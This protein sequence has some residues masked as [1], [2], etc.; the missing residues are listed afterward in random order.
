MGLK[1][2]HRIIIESVVK[3]NPKFLGNEA[4]MDKFCTEVYKKSYLLL[5]SISN[6]ENLKNYLKKVAETS[7]ENVIKQDKSEKKINMDFG[8]PAPAEKKYTPIEPIVRSSYTKPQEIKPISYKE[9]TRVEPTKKEPVISTYDDYSD[10]VSYNSDAVFAGL[11]DPIE[12]S[13]NKNLGNDYAQILIETVV[14]FDIKNPAGRYLDIF[15]M[16]YAE[17]LSQ[18]EIARRLKISQSEL[19][20]RF[21]EITDFITKEAK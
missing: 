16:R 13:S 19:S 12:F 21:V 8:A 14:R 5:D 9:E 20:K 18:N 10:E 6:V 3:E 17:S 1:K 15:K 7:I 11:I 4:L 2:E